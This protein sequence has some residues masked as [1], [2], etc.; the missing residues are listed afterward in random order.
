MNS[1][2]EVEAECVALICCEVLD[3]P[4][5]EFSR[6]YVQHCLRG[7]SIPEKPAARIMQAADRVLKAGWIRSTFTRTFCLE[8]RKKPPGRLRS[9]FEKR[10]RISDDP[11]CREIIR[12]PFG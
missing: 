1:V 3:L 10:L 9:P 4:G 2:H 12:F 8:C 7:D 11:W 6:A 5:P